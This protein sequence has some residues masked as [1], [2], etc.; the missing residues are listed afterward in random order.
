MLL[1]DHEELWRCCL[2]LHYNPVHLQVEYDLPQLAVAS[3]IAEFL[4]SYMEL[5]LNKHLSVISGLDHSKQEIKDNNN[6]LKTTTYFCSSSNWCFLKKI[7]GWIY[8]QSKIKDLLAAKMS[9]LRYV[10]K[11]QYNEVFASSR[12]PSHI[13]SSENR[14]QKA[15]PMSQE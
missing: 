5:W 3:R 13:I 15:S 4:L 11:W 2:H 9:R 12:V 10:L 7:K 14:Q 6:D 1:E 8:I